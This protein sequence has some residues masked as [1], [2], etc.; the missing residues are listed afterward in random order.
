VLEWLLLRFS[1]HRSVLNRAESLQRALETEIEHTSQLESALNAIQS[2]L[3]VE[4]A[5][6]IAAE[7]VSSER[8]AEIQRLLGEVADSRQTER[9]IRDERLKS[10]DTL[11]LKLMESRVEAP[12]PDLAQFHAAT[13]LKNQL[14]DD[15]R[16]RDRAMDILLL[17]KFHPAFKKKAA[18]GQEK[19]VAE[20]G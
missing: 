1:A 19:P 9:S 8:G 4:R 16:K 12:P 15:I 2:D 14:V 6:R 3:Q 10:L 20:G 18:N 11:N 13:K 17:E 5:H 7:S